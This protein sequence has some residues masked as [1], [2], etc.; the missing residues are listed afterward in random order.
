MKGYV[1]GGGG[2]KKVFCILERADLGIYCLI[3]VLRRE[4]LF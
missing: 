3:R 2:V 1:E 4:G